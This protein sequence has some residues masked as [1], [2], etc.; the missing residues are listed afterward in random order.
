M[1]DI[2]LMENMGYSVVFPFGLTFMAFMRFMVM[3]F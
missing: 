3:C 2:K 1:K